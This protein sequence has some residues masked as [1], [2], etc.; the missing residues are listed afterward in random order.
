MN[1]ENIETKE[2]TEL[3]SV[4][5]KHQETKVLSFSIFNDI[6]TIKVGR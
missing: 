1:N 3:A 5:V 6:I 2:M 4:I